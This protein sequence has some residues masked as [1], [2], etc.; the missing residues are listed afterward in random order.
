M[1]V[2]PSFREIDTIKGKRPVYQKENGR[3]I[4]RFFHLVL[5]ELGRVGCVVGFVK[6]LLA[7]VS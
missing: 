4:A 2:R 6:K 7:G 5:R 3:F 1:A